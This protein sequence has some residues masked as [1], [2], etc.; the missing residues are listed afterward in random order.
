MMDRPVERLAS[1]GVLV[2]ALLLFFALALDTAARKAITTDEPIHLT[3]G[4]ALSQS[5]DL[6]LQYEHAPLSHRLIGVLLPFEPTLPL[7]A[8][9]LARPS[10]DRSAIAAELLWDGEVDV[11]RALF[12]GRVPIVWVGTLLGAVV[13]LWTLSATR[14]IPALAVALTL[15]ATSANLLASA[16]LATTDFVAAAT[17]F[18]TICAWWFYGCR[19]TRARWLA[20]GLLLGLALGAKLTGV[21]LVPLLF[22]LAYVY[23]A[24]QGALWRPALTALGLLPMAAVILWAVYGFQIGPWRG[25]VVPAP[26]Y[27]ESWVSVL[28]HVS[29][30]HQAFFLGR[31]SSSGWW[32]YFPVA[33]L[34]KTP[35]VFLGLLAVALMFI[36]RDRALWRVAAFTLLPAAAFLAAAVASRLNIGY[37]H[38]LPVLPFLL[39]T[40]GLVVPALWPRPRARWGL[41]LALVWTAVAALLTHP[42]HLA[43]FNELTLRQGWRYLGDSNLDWGQ[44]VNLLGQYARTYRAETG[45]P[46]FFSYTGVANPAYFGL[47]DL[48]LVWQFQV[49]RTDFAPANPA[50]GRYAIN[51][52]DLQG[53]GLALGALTEIDLLDWFRHRQ[54]LTTLGGSIFI[55]DVP[56]QT[57]GEWIAHCLSPVPLLA[58]DEAERLVGRAGLRHVY[59]DC[60]SNWVFPSGDSAAEGTPGWYVLP[61]GQEWWI[62]DWLYSGSVPKVY[63]HSANEFGPAYEIYY[64]PG[65]WSTAALLSGVAPAAPLLAGTAELWVYLSRGTEWVT[66]WRVTAATAEPLSIVAHLYNDDAPPQ[67][68][69]GLGFTADQWRPGDWF[70]QRHDF[71][72]PGEELETGLYNYVTLQPASE[73]VRLPAN[74]APYGDRPGGR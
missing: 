59:F 57:E 37:R 8:E 48:S 6:S 50:A 44:D 46:L 71:D 35:V 42:D 3:R 19:P 69:D 36:A 12:L 32:L 1:R 26:A 61:S 51:V 28:N 43:Y 9:L 23:P 64:W 20:T 7:V 13:A 2:V 40:I 5:G 65:S 15:Y 24:R 72:A 14:S 73:R 47:D 31:L 62:N 18:A 70:I 29:T 25:L 58:D 10:G 67:V 60:S 74:L 22:V 34:I 55:Y 38:I 16:A 21:L 56:Q 27:W 66:Q 45:R 49:G 54:P 30:G 4:V 63:S 53:S 33:F 68:A 52:S 39:V 11:E 41:G 17:Y